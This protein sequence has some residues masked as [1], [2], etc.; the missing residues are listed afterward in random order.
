[1]FE[2][3]GKRENC[4]SLDE[5]VTRFLWALEI[6]SVDLNLRFWKEETAFDLRKCR[7]SMAHFGLFGCLIGEILT[8]LKWLV[9]RYYS[10]HQGVLPSGLSPPPFSIFELLCRSSGVLG[11]IPTEDD[12][13]Y[14]L[15][16][17]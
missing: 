15:K 8:V 17:T 16:L 12:P 13:N 5:N 3:K 4:I 11:L 9:S 14:A 1:M 7:L 6:E 10:R 2:K